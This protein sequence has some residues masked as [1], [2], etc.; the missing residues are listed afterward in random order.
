MNNYG[1]T[2]LNFACKYGYLS[3]VEYLIS[4]GADIEAKNKYERTPIHV[5]CLNGNLP[6]IEYFV[7]K[8]IGID[9]KN[10]YGQTPIHFACRFGHLNIVQYLI[11]KQHVDKDVKDDND[12]TLLHYACRNDQLDVVEYLILQGADLNATDKNNQT[13]L[14]FACIK[15]H[16]NIVQYL[17][18]KQHVDKDVRGGNDRTPLHCACQFGCFDI[19]KYLISKGANVEAKNN[20]KQIPLYY[21]F[22]KLDEKGNFVLNPE[23]NYETMAILAG[24]TNK[25][26]CLNTI[27]DVYKHCNDE[28]K[29]IFISSILANLII[30]L[31]N[32]KEKPYWK[33]QNYKYGKKELI[34]YLTEEQ[35]SNLSSLISSITDLYKKYGGQQ[36]E[37]KQP[38]LLKYDS[39]YSESRETSSYYEKKE[40]KEKSKELT[41]ALENDSE[42]L[43]I[44]AQNLKLKETVKKFSDT[45]DDAKHLS[46]DSYH[47][48]DYYSD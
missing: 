36:Q 9:I 17:I 10:E 32:L 5:A 14:H 12:W 26:F 35:K 29:E 13:P 31:S 2:L 22:Y 6:I 18:E 45:N 33:Y 8:G 44:I 16:L 48:Y 1:Q 7:S 39:E 37:Q 11:E 38:Q 40:E 24:Y 3:I 28:E 21:I 43:E 27:K 25:E 42:D 41:K 34:K 20:N 46:N 15:G 30:A 47:S 23:P 19:V 4:K